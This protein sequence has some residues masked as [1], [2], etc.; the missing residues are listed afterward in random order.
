MGI[1]ETM[2]DTYTRENNSR[3]L[4]VIFGGTGDLTNRKLVPAVYN[5]FN[6]LKEG[7]NPMKVLI[8]GRRDWTRDECI[9]NVK[10]WVEE[11]SRL[12]YTEDR[13]MSFKEH[14]DYYKMDISNIGEYEALFDYFE[15]EYSDYKMLFY[16]AVAPRFFDTITK[17]L[18]Q[19]KWSEG[20]AKVI[21][22]KPFGE[23][24][25]DAKRLF[26]EMES[27]FGRDYIYHRS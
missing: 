8:I 6:Q 17:G 15:D 21:V 24:L 5:L 27:M 1:G 2:K 22:E 26:R 13:W 11:F 20:K 9:E 3:E 4:L 19:K 14:L 18:G 10:P 7:Q 16:Y 25:E 12:E 23:N